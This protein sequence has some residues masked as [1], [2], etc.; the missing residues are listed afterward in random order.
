M[1]RQAAR[2]GNDG[3]ITAT[4]SLCI[5]AACVISPLVSQASETA[6]LPVEADQ[7][8]LEAM[9]AKSPERGAE[10]LREY[11]CRQSPD[12][13]AVAAEVLWHLAQKRQLTNP[14]AELGA[15][16]LDAEDPFVRALA[17]WALSIKVGLENGGQEARWPG[18]N[19]PAWFRR[20]AGQTPQ[21]MLENDYAR[22]LISWD[23]Y[24]NSKTIATS[25]SEIIRRGRGA[26]GEILPSA[27]PEI[28]A[29]VNE[30]LEELER[31]RVSLARCL[32]EEPANLTAARRLWI[33][34]RQAARPI[35]L[36]NPALDFDSVL[37]V[38]RHSAHSHRNITGSQYPWVHKPGGDIVI[39]K[40][41][42]VGSPVRGVLD[43]RLGP[44]HVHGLDLWWDGDRVV[45]GFAS[46][47]NWP[48]SEDAVHGNRVFD[49]RGTQQPTHLYEIGLDGDGL[50]QLTDDPYWSDL[51]PTYCANGDVVFASDRS[52]R[53]S[54]CGNFNADHTVINLYRVSADGATIERLND[55]KDIDRYPH[56]L[57]NGQIA[58][59]RWE[60]QER[61]F[62]E[63]HALWT[64]RPDGTMADAVFNQHIKAPYA[65]RDTRSV[66][67]SRLLVS[68]A[69]GHHTFAY[70]PVV[71]VDPSAGPNWSGGIRSVT[72]HSLPQEGPP[73]GPAVAEGGVPDRGGLYQTPWALSDR[74]FLASYSHAL[75]ASSTS[76]GGNATGFSLYVLDVHGNKELIHRDPVLSCAFPIPL[77]KRQRP[78]AV[79]EAEPG[80]TGVCYVPDVEKGLEGV[81]KGTVRYLRI[82]Q[83]VGWPLDDSI[84]AMRWIPGNAWTKQF[85]FWAWAPVRVIGTVP[86]EA[87]GSAH[88]ELPANEAV[89]FQAL[90]KDFMEVRRMRSHVTVQPGEVRGCVGCHETRAVTP[91]ADWP[92]PLAMGRDPS[93]PSPPSWGADRL[94]GYEWLVQP[95]LD[96]H[97]TRCHGSQEPD[98]GIDLTGA[99]EEDGLFRSYHSLFGQKTDGS[100]GKPYVSV[101]NRFSGSSVSGIKEFGSHKSRLTSVL[102]EDTHTSEVQLSA[103][104]WSA[105]VTWID[106]NAPYHD[107]FYNRRPAEGPPTRNVD[108]RFP[109]DLASD[110]TH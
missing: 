38:K 30:Q 86:V 32:A 16:W 75:P 100:R 40:G 20:W 74:C 58:Y 93:V 72:P 12:A 92:V 99:C 95:I 81:E 97:C 44:G 3:S 8:A 78:P 85:G 17:E 65:L 62:L 70:G 94:L 55:N 15:E 48:P 7:K 11:G 47:K 64:M 77:R 61:H 109:D 39:Q 53:S 101:S 46:Q 18:E 5:L 83:R 54:E 37:F 108:L 51:E 66:P 91:A 79:P 19:S 59:T 26:A 56:S 36:A 35:V 33:S 13:Q 96:R 57:D 43:G 50:R 14:L 6:S 31:I 102:R 87:D 45:F 76:G 42:E 28:A 21:E 27:S 29:T 9:V 84:G 104:E 88:F 73:P 41:F 4:W 10:L 71:L 63:V 67:A 25:V 90:D 2:R 68:I 24:R 80:A 106:A 110:E 60:Y 52:G 23:G 103:N 1:R 82:S 98:G 22:M 89:Y 69:T 107:T 34:A 49:L 105:M